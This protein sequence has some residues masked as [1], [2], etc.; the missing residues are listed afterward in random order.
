MAGAGSW[1]PKPAPRCAPCSAPTSPTCEAASR[2]C[3]LTW[4]VEDVTTPLPIRR[5][6]L[7]RLAGS[8]LLAGALAGGS[9]CGW[10]QLSPFSPDTPKDV[11]GDGEGLVMQAGGQLVA[12]PGS[13]K[14]ERGNDGAAAE[15]LTAAR[16]L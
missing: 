11:P 13:P 6:R 9:G 2:A 10:D 7:A 15:Q 14:P 8:F 1:T 5:R 16:E 4:G 3:C 12:D